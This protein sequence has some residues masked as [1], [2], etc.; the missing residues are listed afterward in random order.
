M[1]LHLQLRL[2]N[3][4]QTILDVESDIERYPL[5][6]ALKSEMETLKKY[7]TDVDNLELS[8]D[9]VERMERATTLFLNEL[10]L[11]L[12]KGASAPPKKIV[13]Q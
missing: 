8:E 9:D 5:Y 4:L 2:R 12:N 1:A 7:L 3:C 6:D 10:Y 13:L 11:P